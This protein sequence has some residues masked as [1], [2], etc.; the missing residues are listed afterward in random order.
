MT[1]FGDK[2]RFKFILYREHNDYSC[3]ILIILSMLPDRISTK[4]A[5][6]LEAK[7]EPSNLLMLITTYYYYYY[8]SEL[9]LKYFSDVI[10]TFLFSYCIQKHDM[11]ERGSALPPAVQINR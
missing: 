3:K 5:D 1:L 8:F 10:I 4:Q 7:S 6:Q 2:G 11:S 9:T